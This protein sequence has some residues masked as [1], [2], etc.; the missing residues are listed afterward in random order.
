MLFDLYHRIEKSKVMEIFESF[1]YLFCCETSKMQRFLGEFRK[2][3]M[4]NDQIMNLCKNSNGL[5]AVRTKNF[6]G[7]FDFIK[8]KFKIPAKELLKILDH[9]PQ[10]ILQNRRDLIQKKYKLIMDNSPNRSQTYMRNLFRRHPDLFLGSYASMEAKVNY[11]KRNLNR[12]VT[13]EQSFPLLLHFNYTSVM[14]P[15]CELLLAQGQ[16]HFDLA[17][18]LPG[19]DADFCKKFGFERSELK[20]KQQQRQVVEEKDKLWVYVPGI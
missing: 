6:Q 16:R 14:W 13:K 12:H 18:V 11:I 20:A 17:E 19:S 15:R 3:K 9:Y 10:M 7:F 1:P 4:T 2:Y 5:L 8:L